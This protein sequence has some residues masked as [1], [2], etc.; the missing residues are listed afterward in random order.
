MNTQRIRCSYYLASSKCS[1]LDTLT[2]R[3]A[4]SFFHDRFDNYIKHE[5]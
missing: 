2:E 3:A 1:Q 4:V 5:D